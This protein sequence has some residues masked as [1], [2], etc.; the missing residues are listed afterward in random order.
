MSVFCIV[1]KWKGFN[2]RVGS[3]H[4][5]T[6]LHENELLHLKVCEEHAYTREYYE[7][8]CKSYNTIK[9]ELPTLYAHCALS[10]AQPKK[11]YSILKPS[12]KLR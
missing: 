11:R 4:Y 10:V 3:Q 9:Y 1:G 7:A 8:E 6:D 2:Y 12:I 5:H